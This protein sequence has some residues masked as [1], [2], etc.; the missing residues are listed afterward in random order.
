VETIDEGLL[1]LGEDS[2]SLFKR[3]FTEQLKTYPKAIAKPFGVIHCRRGGSDMTSAFTIN[4]LSW[5]PQTGW[6]ENGLSIPLKSQVVGSFGSGKAKFK[7]WSDKFQS[8]DTGGTSRAVFQAFCKTLQEAKDPLIG[9]PPQL[10]SLV[11][12]GNGKQQGVVWNGE[13]WLAGLRLNKG[14][15]SASIEF[16]DA[17]FQRCDPASLTLIEGAQQQPLPTQVS[18]S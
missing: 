14:D 15:F 7:Y 6:S 16:R 4:H 3:A 1:V 12:V 8:S 11:R 5:T 18:S 2:H 9:G 10:A 13:A 17:L